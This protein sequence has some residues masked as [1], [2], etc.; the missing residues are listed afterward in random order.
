MLRSG[1]VF[2]YQLTRFHVSHFLSFVFLHFVFL[3]ISSFL[4]ST[5]ILHNSML[6]SWHSH[7]YPSSLFPLPAPFPLL[8][9]LLPLSLSLPLLF[10]F[11]PCFTFPSSAP[12]SSPLSFSTTFSASFSPSPFSLSNQKYRDFLE[13]FGDKDVGLITGDVSVNPDASC[14]IMTTG[15][16][17]VR[18]YVMCTYILHVC[19]EALSMCVRTYVPCQYGYLVWSNSLFSLH[20]AVFIALH[21]S[22]MTV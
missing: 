2:S 9:S 17:S 21:F 13:K 15:K 4:S 14:L 10:Y 6:S 12:P 7:I 19:V 16:Y 1:A 5:F 3:L 20:I 8:T 22:S 11:R 18:K